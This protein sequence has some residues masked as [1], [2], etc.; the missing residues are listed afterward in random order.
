MSWRKQIQNLTI[1]EKLTRINMIA[2]GS[3]ILLSCLI[4]LVYQFFAQRDALL[5]DM[6]AQAG[7]LGKSLYY[8][9]S[10]MDAKDA[11]SVLSELEAWP[12]FLQADIY[13]VDGNLFAEYHAP[14][15]KTAVHDF[16]KNRMG[17]RWDFRTMS[18]SQEINLSGD[19]IG[20]I[21]LRRDMNEM[22]MMLS[23]N[24]LVVWI[25][26]VLS[27][28][29]AYFIS[30]RLQRYISEPIIHLAE[31]TKQ[32]SRDQ[33]FSIRA[34]KRFE[35]EVGVLID[36]FNAMLDQIEAR[37]SAL[38]AAKER[39]E[40]ISRDLAKHRDHLADL[41]SDKEQA[42]KM[43]RESE[44]KYRGIFE[45]A[46]EGIFQ[47]R[48]DGTIL[49]ANPA[50]AEI[51]GYPSVE[52]MVAGI[53]QKGAAFF[54]DPE[55]RVHYRRL[56]AQE[57]AVRN[58]ETRLRRADGTAV[59]VNLNSH[60]VH[61]E[62]GELLYFE[63]ILVDISER[64][65]AEALKIAKD[66]AEAATE[67]KSVFLANM[68]H[69][70]RTPMNAII[71]MTNIA[72]KTDLNEKQRGYLEMIEE[73][74]DSLLGIINDILDFSK[75]EAGKLEL[76]D[77]EFQLMD[78]LDNLG[79]LFSG[80]AAEKG[81]EMLL[82]N[83]PSVPQALVGD[84]LRL[85][86]VLVNL[87]A[88]AVK[89]TEEGEVVV[90]VSP[91]EITDEHA[92]LRFWVRD[93]GIGIEDEHKN[94]L[95]DSFSQADGSTTRKYGGT[96]LG[97]AICRRLVAIMGGD[98]EVKS[99]VGVG[100]E[101]SF[102]LNFRRQPSE[103]EWQPSPPEDCRG[104]RVLIVDDNRTSREILTE[105]L[106]TLTFEVEAAA[107]GAE[108]FKLL[109]LKPE[110][111]QLV[112]LDWRMS[113]MDGVETAKLLR[114]DPRFKAIPIIL[115]TA[116]G[117]E[118]VSRRGDQVGIEAYLE[119]PVKQSSL[120]DTIMDV[121]GKRT[122][123]YGGRK[124][125]SLSG[126]A[127]TRLAGC[128]ILLVE[129]NAINQRVARE[130]LEGVGI[131]MEIAGNGRIALS[132]LEKNHFDI[133]LMD[134]QMPEMDGY[135]ATK[136]IRHQG[137][138]IP[139]IAMTAHAMKGDREKCLNAGMSDY[140]TKPIDPD[141]LF[142]VLMKWFRGEPDPRYAPAGRF[143]SGSES[144]PPNLPGL[145]IKSG[146]GRIAGNERLYRELLEEFL[147]EHATPLEDIRQLIRSDGAKQAAKAAHL[148][149][150]VSG[151]LGAEQLHQAAGELESLLNE[152]RLE[153]FETAGSYYE[154][155]LHEVLDSIHMVLVN[156]GG[157]P[158]KSPAKPVKSDAVALEKVQP[159]LAE[160]DEALKNHDLEAEQ[161]AESLS[162]MLP[163]DPYGKAMEQMS[164]AIRKF[165]FAA[166]RKA[167]GQVAEL[168][169]VPLG[170][171]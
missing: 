102:E 91:V 29:V 85:R 137:L 157:T 96:G 103:R 128:R 15:L 35:D 7:I 3:A 13:D 134:V 39:A 107:S 34:P 53:N 119:K 21:Y 46:T 114:G 110:Y 120:F 154:A 71:G 125:G 4:F 47:S 70:I 160:L 18:L 9:L 100:S 143:N 41:V 81:I 25:C 131:R 170:G 151:N 149:K 106:T 132:S 108:A 58:F 75:I 28:L 55:D 45:N 40:D 142:N 122:K 32:V 92:R 10:F 77:A 66:A 97:L 83:E 158:A 111:F 123:S 72:L 80:K 26:I 42:E 168:L 37:D 59:H 153:G 139:I 11:A 165:D 117:L 112:L 62:R 115:M 48:E 38:V 166:A 67:A 161:L 19:T 84:A 133:I 169:A 31:I 146:L 63:G 51:L 159:L 88:N 49:M 24:F 60:A 33:D 147:Q 124:R 138:D 52:K 101:F 127:S 104:L 129:D 148:V 121:F 126:D 145:N 82:A 136:A 16:D 94:R 12:S 171:A 65:R 44:K 50:M 95:F 116:F 36:G 163:D 78:V 150:G 89:F 140:V 30:G 68:S 69:E 43:L 6:R 135:Q 74:A 8:P 23:R 17:S 14:E 22:W 156:Q 76:E 1:R 105:M 167:L 64:K 61:G 118:E 27:F 87:T 109:E 2:G 93:T 152:N 99:T 155:A 20:Y 164:S 56:L 5:N 73:A 86:Q 54:N 79:S 162:V 98:I 130:I 90:G 113:G 57:G 144:L 141:R